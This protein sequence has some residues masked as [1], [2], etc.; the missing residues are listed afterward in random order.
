MQLVQGGSAT[1]LGCL[2]DDLQSHIFTCSA[3]NSEYPELE[4]SKFDYKNIFSHDV[5]EIKKLS[6]G[7]IQAM[8]KRKL[9]IDRVNDPNLNIP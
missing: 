5:K 6:A 9:V 4:F 3:L 2:E 8:E 1:T 7:L